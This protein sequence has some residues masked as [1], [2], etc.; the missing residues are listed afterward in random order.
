M[1]FLCENLCN[2]K[3]PIRFVFW[4][5]RLLFF[6]NLFSFVTLCF[7]VPLFN[8][9]LLEK[10]VQFTIDT[11]VEPKS[12]FCFCK[13]IFQLTSKSIRGSFVANK[14]ESQYLEKLQISVFVCEKR[15][16]VPWIYPN[17]W[18]LST[19]TYRDRWSWSAFFFLAWA[20]DGDSVRILW[21]GLLLTYEELTQPPLLLNNAWKHLVS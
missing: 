10:D 14:Q 2:I 16:L 20:S 15:P 8:I 13:A 1:S 9:L 21:H 18:L 7:L 3:L 17:M 19:S 5:L 4:D 6:L 12:V 11:S